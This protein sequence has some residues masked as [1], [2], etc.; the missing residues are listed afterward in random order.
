MEDEASMLAHR[1]FFFHNRKRFFFLSDTLFLFLQQYRNP[2]SSQSLVEGFIEDYITIQRTLCSS[3]SFELFP[4]L[5]GPTVCGS[6]IPLK[7][8]NAKTHISHKASSEKFIS[9]RFA[10]YDHNKKF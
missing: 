2:K 4:K 3:F 8:L 1:C 9:T 6:C 10:F 5:G 7:S